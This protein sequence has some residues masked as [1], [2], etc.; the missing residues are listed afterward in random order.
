[1]H[2]PSPKHVAR[3]V[4][5][6]GGGANQVGF[7][8]DVVA[9]AGLLVPSRRVG[10]A[11]RV[12]GAIGVAVEALRVGGVLHVG[13]HREEAARQ[14]VVAASVH[15]DEAEAGHVFLA[16]EASVEHQR[17]GWLVGR[18][19]EPRFGVAACT[20]RVIREFLLYVAVPYEF[21]HGLINLVSKDFHASMV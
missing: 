6:V 2:T 19:V 7:R 8:V 3:V 20:P 9:R 12:V 21:S 15:V 13:V 17:R 14:R 16:C 11:Q 18:V 4:G 10:V 5:L 1:M